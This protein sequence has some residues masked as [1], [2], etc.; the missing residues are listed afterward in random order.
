[1]RGLEAMRGVAATGWNMAI[2]G[3]NAQFIKEAAIQ[4]CKYDTDKFYEDAYTFFD[5]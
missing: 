5:D 1:M 3:Y 2:N 4:A